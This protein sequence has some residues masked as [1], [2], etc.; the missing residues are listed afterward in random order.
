MKFRNLRARAAQV[1]PHLLLLG[2]ILL[3]LHWGGG[4]LMNPAQGQVVTAEY[5]PEPLMVHSDMGGDVGL[6]A[7]RIAAMR[8][9][10]QSVRILGPS[11][12]SA[13]TMYLSLPGSCISRNTQFGFHRPSYYGAALSPSQFEY[14]SKVIAAHYPAPLQSWY[15]SEGRYSLGLQMISGAELIRL[16]V[17]ECG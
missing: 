10:R 5:S 2:G 1:C 4:P 17:A 11:C 9:N 6:R 15:L 16:G 7:N 8:S 3:G 12:Y 14:W 13:C